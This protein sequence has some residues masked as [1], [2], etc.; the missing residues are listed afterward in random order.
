M[1]RWYFAYGSNMNPQRVASRGL[2][3]DTVRGG[4]L[5]GYRLTFD[6]QSSDHPRSG[7]AN[8]TVD[9]QSHVEG[10]LYRLRDPN[11]I[12]L[13]DRFERTP[14]NY[15]REIVEVEADAEVILS[16]TYFANPGVIRG[17]LRPEREYLAHLLA[18][19]AYL[20]GSY[21]AFLAATV[22]IDE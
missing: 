5:R 12:A 8:L 11:E 13:M 2:T 17:N 14:I 3:F 21:H 18:G 22:C 9:P 4:V 19:R 16:W 7:H 20:S 1:T 15:R 10:V 6:K